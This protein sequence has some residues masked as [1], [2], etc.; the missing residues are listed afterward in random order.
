MDHKIDTKYMFETIFLFMFIIYLLTARKFMT[1]FTWNILDQLY[2][3]KFSIW[4]EHL[5]EY[6][7]AIWFAFGMFFSLS[8]LIF[9]N[10]PH[11]SWSIENTLMIDCDFEAYFF[12]LKSHWLINLLA[13]DGRNE[14]KGINYTILHTLSYQ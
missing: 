1:I 12:S 13:N 5:V 4:L 11:E 10:W 14:K 7:Y 2:L 9:I 8:C 3:L 6:C